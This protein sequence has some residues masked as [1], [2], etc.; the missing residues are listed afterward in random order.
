M[1]ATDFPSGNCKASDGVKNICLAENASKN[2]P[3][4]RRQTQS[5]G[6]GLESAC[7]CQQ[8]VLQSHRAALSPPLRSR[9]VLE[10]RRSPVHFLQRPGLSRSPIQ[11]IFIEVTA[12]LP[13]SPA[14]LSFPLAGLLLLAVNRGKRPWQPRTTGGMGKLSLPTTK[15]S[16]FSC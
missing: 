2:S 3:L 14:N 6:D 12:S 8:R 13:G 7:C 1:H 9:D 5:P 16:E 11:Q 10:T 4:S 15:T